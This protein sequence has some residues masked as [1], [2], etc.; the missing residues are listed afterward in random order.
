MPDD[1]VVQHVV[2]RDVDQVGPLVEDTIFIPLG[3]SCRA[4]SSSIFSCDRRSAVGERLLVLPHQD[5]AL[6]DVVRRRPRPDDAQPRAG[7][8]R[9]PW[10]SGG[11]RPGMLLYVVTT[12]SWMSSSFSTS[13]A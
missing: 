10:R 9:P 8:R 12:T 2:G 7:S 11:R 1:Q 3:S 6:D 5:D 4:L 13:I